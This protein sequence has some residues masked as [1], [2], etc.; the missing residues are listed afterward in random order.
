MMG[1]EIA[2]DHDCSVILSID[3]SLEMFMQFGDNAL[4]AWVVDIND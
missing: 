4:V 3:I 1:V 2:S